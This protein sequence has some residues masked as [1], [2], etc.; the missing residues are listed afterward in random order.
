VISFLKFGCFSQGVFDPAIKVL[1]FVRLLL[2]GDPS[3][4][5]QFFGSSSQR[6]EV[7]LVALRNIGGA[8]RQFCLE[9]ERLLVL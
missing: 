3:G 5:F 4:C 6:V 7:I 2:F 1:H 9:N 8:L